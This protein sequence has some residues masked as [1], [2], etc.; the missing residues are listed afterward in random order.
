MAHMN[1]E[2]TQPAFVTAIALA[3]GLVVRLALI[4]LP[5]DRIKVIIRRVIESARRPATPEQVIRV[6][7]A[8]DQAS[9]WSPVRL[10]CLERSLSAAILLAARGRG[11]TW[12]MGVRTPPFAAHAWIADD[13]GQPIGEPSSTATYQPLLTISWTDHLNRSLK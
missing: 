10:A 2:G 3:V 5:F 11:V 12:R 1:D 6:L 7:A 4:A 8:I 13:S 9:R